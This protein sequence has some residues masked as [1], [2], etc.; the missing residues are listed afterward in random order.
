ME[1]ALPVDDEHRERRLRVLQQTSASQAQD[2]DR[3]ARRWY[4]DRIEGHRSPASKAM[5]AGTAIDDTYAQ[6]YL[7][8][9]GIRT[10]GEWGWL[11]PALATVLPK[12]E[13]V[14]AVQWEFR[15]PTVPDGPIWHGYAD[16]LEEVSAERVHVGDLK[17]V[18]D[19]Q[20]AK[21]RAELLENIQMLSYAEAAYQV[22]APAEVS[23]GHVV[24]RRKPPA[25]VLT[26]PGPN[27]API[28]ISRQR[29]ADEWGGRILP[30]VGE[31]MLIARSATHARDVE[32]NT[33]A[34][35]DFGGCAHR[36][37]C[38]LGAGTLTQMFKKGPTDMST[39][40]T[41]LS[42]TE[43]LARAKAAREAVI[44]TTPL[45]AAATAPTPVTPMAAV[46][47]IP[48]ATTAPAPAPEPIA[49]KPESP[50]TILPPDAPGRTST[51]KE[52]E[53]EET[54]VA[55]KATRKKAEKPAPEAPTLATLPVLPQL[56]TPVETRAKIVEASKALQS[57][58]DTH[59]PQR[60]ARKKPAAPPLL[61]I[62]CVPE[63]G[64]VAVPLET[65]LEPIA[66][67]A[68]AAYVD[69]KTGKVGVADWRLISYTAKGVLAVAIREAL[70]T[71]PSAL[72]IDTRQSGA[73]VA[74]EV[75]VPHAGLVVRGVR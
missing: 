53:A 57:E 34:C 1:T 17:S 37:R 48:A 9:E 56:Q 28:L 63:V 44:A 14:L 67:L 59:V 25:R 43:R 42:L 58:L 39:N 20:W 22:L 73:E 52:V 5:A 19:L 13:R 4:Y 62:D 31:M 30:I 21:T 55:A 64:V 12:P 72:R 46:T 18:S 23:I 68:A 61:F 24:V 35:G 47:P 74:L 8:G 71:C 75:L 50:F 2:C 51:A 60:A 10:D 38:G 6:P 36:S 66:E 45:P 70:D 32:P 26:V 54:K 40:G 15:I 33:A 49:E 69:E 3:C 11:M 7:R 41:T 29:A 27:E 16:W 65:W